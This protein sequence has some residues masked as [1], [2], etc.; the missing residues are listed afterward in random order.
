MTECVKCVIWSPLCADC[1]WS[2]SSRC[3]CRY[4]QTDAAT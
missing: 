1:S 2:L 3:C 4:Y